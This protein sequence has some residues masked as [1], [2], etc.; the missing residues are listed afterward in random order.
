MAKLKALN[1]TS[2]NLCFLK[3]IFIYALKRCQVIPRLVGCLDLLS[4]EDIFH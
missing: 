2:L 3:P 4:D 1:I